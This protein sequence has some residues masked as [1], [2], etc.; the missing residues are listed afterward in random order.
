[1]NR[2][3]SGPSN[4]QSRVQAP[5]AA[6]DSTHSS[7]EQSAGLRSRRPQVR[8]LL[9]GPSFVVSGCR[10]IRPELRARIAEVA[11]SNP[12]ALTSRTAT[13]WP[14]QEFGVDSDWNKSSYS[15]AR[16]AGS[17]DAAV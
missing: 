13:I 4:R 11:G 9:G 17:G 6:P 3:A 15:H 7:A 12:A 5:P 14:L 1:M 10:S 16:K 2:E 8:I